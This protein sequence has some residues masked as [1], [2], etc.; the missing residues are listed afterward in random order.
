MRRFF[1][2]NSLIGRKLCLNLKLNDYLAKKE[3][4]A[5]IFFQL[6]LVKCSQLSA[7]LFSKNTKE[8][9]MGSILK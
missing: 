2:G 4:V 8:F 1:V 9:D 6:F 7:I 5:E 3:L